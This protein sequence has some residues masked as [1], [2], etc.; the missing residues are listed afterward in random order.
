MWGFVMDASVQGEWKVVPEAHLQLPKDGLSR[1]R[2]EFAAKDHDGHD[3]KDKGRRLVYYSKY[4]LFKYSFSQTHS[5]SSIW[6]K[7]QK[8]GQMRAIDDNNSRRNCFPWKPF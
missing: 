6:V 2:A 3:R 8:W 4:S 5:Q 1:E 7:S